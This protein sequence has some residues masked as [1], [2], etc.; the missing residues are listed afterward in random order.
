MHYHVGKCLS[1]VFNP[2]TNNEY[3]IKDSFHT[4]TRIKNCLIKVVDLYQ[5]MLHPY[6]PTCHYKKQ[7]TLY[8]KKIY[9]EKVIN[10]NIKKNTMRKLKKDTSKKTVFVFDNEIYEQIDGVSMELPLAPVLV[11]IIMT[12]LERTIIKSYLILKRSFIIVTLMI[13]YY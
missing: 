1:E 12:E 2:I 9:A 6:S 3:T 13:L 8:F 4:A 11:N 5:L 10:I 7:S